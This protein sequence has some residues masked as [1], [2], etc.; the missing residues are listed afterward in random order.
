MASAARLRPP[1]KSRTFHLKVRDVGGGKEGSAG[2]LAKRLLKFK[3]LGCDDDGDG[4]YDGVEEDCLSDPLDPSSIPDDTDSDGV[5]DELDDDVDG[6]GIGN[7]L[8]D[9]PF[10]D[11]ESTDTDGDG[12]G[13]SSDPDDDN[14]G[15]LH[16][17]TGT[18]T[19]AQSTAPNPS[20]YSITFR[21]RMNTELV[22]WGIAPFSCIC[23][24][25]TTITTI[26]GTKHNLT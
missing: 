20:N 18:T 17:T 21:D 24:C 10:D 23:I 11:S 2:G 13:D 7:D 5:C 22:P 6:D 25:R 8:D 9:F 16:T 4:F 15:Y 1:P 26:W 3:D 19:T 14:D 12:I